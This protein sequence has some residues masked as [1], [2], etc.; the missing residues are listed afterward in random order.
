MFCALLFGFVPPADVVGKLPRHL[1]AD[2]EATGA[3]LLLCCG[4]VGDGGFHRRKSA[5][6][7]AR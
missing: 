5:I 1:P 6:G 2:E 3:R 7:V 4:R